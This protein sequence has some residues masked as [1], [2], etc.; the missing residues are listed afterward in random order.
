M[1]ARVRET[2]ERID[3]K[4]GPLI[5]VILGSVLVGVAIAVGILALQIR[6]TADKTQVIAK[7]NAALLAEVQ[8]GRFTNTQARCESD[9]DLYT[10]IQQFVILRRP[11]ARAQVEA[12]FPLTKDCEAFAAGKVCVGKIAS[13]SDRCRDFAEK[14]RTHPSD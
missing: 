2:I 12:A 8:A 9:N 14:Q 10:K 5:S 13:T 4:Y 6:G 11:D 7:N 3:A 1:P